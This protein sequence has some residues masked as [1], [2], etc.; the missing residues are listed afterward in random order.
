VKQP[1]GTPNSTFSLET[2][3][4]NRLNDLM[5]TTPA[6]ACFDEVAKSGASALQSA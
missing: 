5:V 4:T 3:L 2:G 6:A 1:I